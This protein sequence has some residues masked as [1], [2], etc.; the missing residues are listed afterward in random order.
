MTVVI[1]TKKGMFADS[2]EQIGGLN[3]RVATPKVVRNKMGCLIG[4]SGDSGPI[5]GFTRWFL[6][7][8]P[9]K[10]KRD[11]STSPQGDYTMLILTPSGTC[12]RCDDGG[13]FFE[14]ATPA[15]TGDGDAVSFALGAM[16]MGATPQQ[17]I[18][19]SLEY[20]TNVL[21]PVQVEFL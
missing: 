6:D 7:G 17:A 12:F 4:G 14:V 13:S 5:A 19:L 2:L 15:L 10:E 8:M 21:G 9:L 20:C 18:E 1:A 16:A 11:A 3:S